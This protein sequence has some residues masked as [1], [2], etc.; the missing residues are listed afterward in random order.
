MGGTVC[1][2][3][4]RQH[5]D[6]SHGLRSLGASSRPPMRA[7]GPVRLSREENKNK[8]NI[9]IKITQQKKGACAVQ[10]V[11]VWCK[12]AFVGSSALVVPFQAADLQMTRHTAIIHA[13]LPQHGEAQDRGC[14]GHPRPTH[15]RHGPAA[16]RARADGGSGLRSAG[17]PARRHMH[18][19]SGADARQPLQPLDAVLFAGGDP[20]A[21]FIKKIELHE[22]VP[23]ISS[24]FHGSSR[25]APFDKVHGH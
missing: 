15:A 18:P 22:V 21:K 11:C 24:P 8:N 14:H 5:G 23:R 19:H 6:I 7:N 9:K 10:C 13:R 4:Y 25:S 12:L 20:V 3:D 1:L 2:Q 17:L 16:C